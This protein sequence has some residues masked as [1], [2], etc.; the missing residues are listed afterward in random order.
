V[1]TNEPGK[2]RRKNMASKIVW[3]SIVTNIASLKIS[4]HGKVGKLYQRLL[5]Y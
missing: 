4:L 1:G 3:P 2:Q 5:E